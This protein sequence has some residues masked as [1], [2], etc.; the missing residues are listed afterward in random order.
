MIQAFLSACTTSAETPEEIRHA[1]RLEPTG[2]PVAFDGSV[3]SSFDDYIKDRQSH[4]AEY[5]VFQ[6]PSNREE[7]LKIAA[8]FRIDPFAESA[9][10][11]C[12][13]QTGATR[14]IVLIHGLSDM[15]AAMK[16]L[17]HAFAVR[18]FVTYSVLL[19]GHGA[20]ASEMLE[21]SRHD[22]IAAVQFAVDAMG[23]EVDE[24]YVGGFSL[25]GL[26]AVQTAINNADVAGVFG[27][28]PALSLHRSFFLNQTVWIRL[29]K[30]WLDTDPPDD[31]WR[32]ESIPLSLIHI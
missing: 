13:K 12:K 10:G 11:Q 30:D 29:F 23:L 1:L 20:R 25:G 5:K 9:S 7:E 16:D 8:P 2:I 24:V 6:N 28:S 14:G 3:F 22:W 26:L 27:F 19:P 32:F 15:P 4:L 21:V 31:P 18:C 17:A